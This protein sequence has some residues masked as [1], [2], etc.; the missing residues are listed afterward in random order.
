MPKKYAKKRLRDMT[1]PG[2]PNRPAPSYLDT[3]GTHQQWD[4]GLVDE[5]LRAVFH[6]AHA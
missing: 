2:V 4:Q 6:F 3:L 5:S 1:I